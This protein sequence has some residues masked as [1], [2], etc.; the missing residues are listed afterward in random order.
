MYIIKSFFFLLVTRWIVNIF[1][2]SKCIF[3]QSIFIITKEYGSDVKCGSIDSGIITKNKS[4][5]KK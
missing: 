5:W 3:E 1:R 4:Q 2:I